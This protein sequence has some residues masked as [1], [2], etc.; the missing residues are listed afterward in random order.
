MFN[1]SLARTVKTTS[2]TPDSLLTLEQQKHLSRSLFTRE[3]RGQ[4]SVIPSTH[5]EFRTVHAVV[6]PVRAF[7]LR[8]TTV[9]PDFDLLFGLL[10]DQSGTESQGGTGVLYYD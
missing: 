7:L 3:G 2:A 8:L 6:P 10:C 9:A 4:L 1:D 5:S